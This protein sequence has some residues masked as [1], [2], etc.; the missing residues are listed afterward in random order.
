MSER[1]ISALYDNSPDTLLNLSLEYIS[2]NLDIYT[3]WDLE[4]GCW[5]LLKCIRLPAEISE[6]LLQV[7]QTKKRVDDHFAKLFRDPSQTRLENLYLRDTKISTECVQ[8]LL[9]HKPRRLELLQCDNLSNEWLDLLSR[10]SENLVSL[11]LGPFNRDVITFDRT[12]GYRQ[13]YNA[14]NAPK[15]RQLSVQCR[16]SPLCPI[17]LT[18][19]L[20]HLTHLELFDF[21]TSATTW[22]LC[23]MKNLRYLVLHNVS[24]SK[25]IVDWIKKLHLLI[26]LDISYANEQFGKFARPNEVLAGLVT[27]LIHLESLDISGTNLAGTGSAVPALTEESTSESMEDAQVAQVRCDIPGLVSRVNKPLQFLGLYGTQYGACKRHDIPAKVITGDSNEDQLLTAAEVYIERPGILTRVLNDLYYKFRS[28]ERY[29][30]YASRTLCVVLDAMETHVEEKHIQISCSAIL[31]YIMKGREKN[32]IG[33]KLKKRIIIALLDGME[34]H[35]EDETLMRNGCLTLCQFKIPRDVLFAYERVVRLLLSGVVD[36]THDGF[37]QRIAIYLLN[38]LACHVDGRQKRL[39]G[40]HDAIEKM[41]FLVSDR[42]DRRL[43]DD[44]LEVAWSTMWNVTD[45]TP[46]NCMRFLANHG[47]HYFLD[48]LKNFPDKEE[49]LRN[50]MGLLGNVAE[51]V[52]LRPQLMNK[53]F[54]NVFNQ[55]LDSSSDGIEVSYNAAG[56]LAHIASDGPE[57]WTVEEPS[58]PVVLERIAAA[59]E[60]WD[61]RAERNINYRSFEPILTLLHVY[62]TPQCQHWAVWALANLTTV[63]PS[64]YC[65]LVEVEGGVELLYAILRHPAPYQRIKKLAMIV[66][67]NCEAFSSGYTLPEEEI[68]MP[69][70]K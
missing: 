25:A 10:N 35:L 23:E 32:R 4:N 31:F 30:A 70:N 34:A 65:S 46:Q 68:V 11:K 33:I 56:V 43:C 49:L 58:R 41:L 16:G 29:T 69:R 47:M 18:K 55:L 13:R 66:I 67:N 8:Y 7:Y 5:T 17:L 14:I 61:R 51:V 26:H 63:Y 27:S 42:L 2:N 19:P 24:W 57:A 52:A 6:R 37:V 22:T 15:L 9:E 50:M 64:K 62:H 3:K 12:N 44:V 38:S 60:R 40:H 48:C 28:T 36:G 53:L 1:K 54:L 39:L 45:E 59:I 20:C 21:P